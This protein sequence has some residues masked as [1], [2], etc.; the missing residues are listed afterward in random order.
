MFAPH[1]NLV[2]HKSFSGAMVLRIRSGMSLAFSF[3]LLALMMG[4]QGTAVQ[5]APWSLKSI[6]K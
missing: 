1:Q 3:I 6:R 2:S 5:D 4:A